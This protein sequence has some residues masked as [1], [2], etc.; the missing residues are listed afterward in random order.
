MVHFILFL[1]SFSSSSTFRCFPPEG[2]ETKKRTT[3]ARLLKGL[4][5]VNRRDRASHQNTAAQA[6]VRVST[7]AIHQTILIHFLFNLT[8]GLFHCQKETQINIIDIQFRFIN[9]IIYIN[10]NYFVLCYKI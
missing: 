9:N 10:R 6:Q 5:T 4:K 2:R 7:T 1:F 8:Y 3:L